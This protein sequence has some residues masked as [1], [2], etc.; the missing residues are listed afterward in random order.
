M[1]DENTRLARLSTC[2]LETVC[3]ALQRQHTHVPQISIL[4]APLA[5]SILTK[6]G[7]TAL[8]TIDHICAGIQ[9]VIN[10]RRHIEWKRGSSAFAGAKLLDQTIGTPL[11]SLAG[12]DR[13][14]RSVASEGAGRSSRVCVWP[15]LLS[16][17]LRWEISPITKFQGAASEL[18]G[19]H[20]LPVLMECRWT[21]FRI[22]QGAAIVE[23]LDFLSS[24]AGCEMVV[25]MVRSALQPFEQTY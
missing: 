16:T 10:R 9:A 5:S 22:D 12:M 19:V 18:Q 4:L 7:V 11:L 21:L 20:L 8:P 17:D 1:A 25:F 23:Y 13:L 6:T 3:E 15:S 2:N 24:S 14:L